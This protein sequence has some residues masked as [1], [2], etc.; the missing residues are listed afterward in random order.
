MQ[1]PQMVQGYGGCVYHR[2]KVMAKIKADAPSNAMAIP[3]SCVPEM[4]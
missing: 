1:H 4:V 2:N 3:C